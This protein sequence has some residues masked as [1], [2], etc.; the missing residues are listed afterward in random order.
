MR[1]TGK[2]FK[3]FTA[4]FPNHLDLVSSPEALSAVA[5]IC[6]A[7]PIA[8]ED[9]SYILEKM[10]SKLKPTDPSQVRLNVVFLFF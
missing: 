3:D 1:K 4:N 10:I 8:I 2:D 7:F 6:S 9:S 5:W